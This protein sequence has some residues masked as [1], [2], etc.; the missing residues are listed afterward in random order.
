VP[1]LQ[2]LL[3]VLVVVH[4]R[5]RVV[6]RLRSG[7]AVCRRPGVAVPRCLVLGE[8]GLVG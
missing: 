4:R 7:V 1:V 6:Q 5:L 3:P 8:L 2:A